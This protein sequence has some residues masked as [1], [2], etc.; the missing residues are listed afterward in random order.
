MR[1]SITC[2]KYLGGVVKMEYAAVE[3][4]LLQWVFAA[5]ESWRIAEVCQSGK[6]V[7]QQSSLM[8]VVKHYAVSIGCPPTFIIVGLPCCHNRCTRP[9]AIKLVEQYA[10]AFFRTCFLGIIERLPD[11]VYPCV[12]FYERAYWRVFRQMFYEIPRP[13]VCVESA[14]SGS[15]RH[16]Y[17]LW[18]AEDRVLVG[19][20]VIQ[21]GYA[22]TFPISLV[23]LIIVYQHAR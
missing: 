23:S 14:A 4:F 20:M 17:T 1:Q 13:L 15:V 8:A 6:T 18:S 3:S 22:N 16:R 19:C 5:D 10:V 12:Q 21:F 11:T 2:S 7:F 9:F